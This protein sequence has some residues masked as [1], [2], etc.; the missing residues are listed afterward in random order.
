[1]N[2]MR[3]RFWN[4]RQVI[5]HTT[6]LTILLTSGGCTFYQAFSYLSAS[7]ASNYIHPTQLPWISDKSLCENTG[8][9]WHEHQCWDYEHNSGF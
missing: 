2:Y 7:S 1:M 4:L 9:T 5:V 3:D 6:F 8:R